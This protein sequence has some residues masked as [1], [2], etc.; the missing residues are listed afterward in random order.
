MLSVKHAFLAVVYEPIMIKMFMFALQ[1]ALI[2]YAIRATWLFDNPGI[3]N[4]EVSISLK[5]FI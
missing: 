1:R 4:F 3:S 2:L 5:F